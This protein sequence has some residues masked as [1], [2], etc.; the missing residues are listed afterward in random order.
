MRVSTRQ[1]VIPPSPAASCTLSSRQQG[2]CPKEFQSH[3]LLFTT[4]DLKSLHV[5]PPS[6]TDLNSLHRKGKQGHVLNQCI[7]LLQPFQGLPPLVR[8]L[9]KSS[10][11]ACRKAMTVT[12]F[13]ITSS[14][15]NRIESGDMTI[16]K[17]ASFTRQVTKQKQ[18][19]RIR[20]R[21]NIFNGFFFLTICWECMD[22]VQKS[23]SRAER[24]FKVWSILLLVGLSACPRFGTK[25]RKLETYL[26]W[27][28]IQVKASKPYRH[29]KWFLPHEEAGL[30]HKKIICAWHTAHHLRSV[31]MH[32]RSRIQ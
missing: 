10:S 21:V 16:A 2:M 13:A 27:S 23:N 15:D 14:K 7:T 11:Q 19:F 22:C 26:I 28:C 6:W 1:Q 5:L 24:F 18:M 17:V 3:Q 9:Q 8:P 20:D 30:I 31:A 4:N 12:G 32:S 25:A 29:A